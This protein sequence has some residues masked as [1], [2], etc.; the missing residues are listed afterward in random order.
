M[1]NSDTEDIRNQSPTGYVYDNESPDNSYQGF[2]KHKDHN[3]EAFMKSHKQEIAFSNRYLYYY[4]SLIRK[5]YG[6]VIRRGDDQP[7]ERYVGHLGEQPQR[8]ELPSE[9]HPKTLQAG[10]N[11][12]PVANEIILFR[13]R[14]RLLMGYCKEVH[15]RQVSEVDV[16]TE[17]ERHFR[18]HKTNLIYL[19]GI[20]VQSDA[21]ELYQYARTIR[22]LSQQIDLKL[23]WELALESDTALNFDEI[24]ELYWTDQQLDPTRW[25]A[26]YLYLNQ[27]CPY[28]TPTQDLYAPTS[29]EE[30]NQR[31]AI[32]NTRKQQADER[33]EFVN[34][35]RDEKDTDTA[36]LTK[37]QNI[38]LSHI[39]QYALWGQEASRSTEARNILSDL[40]PK[41]KNYK[42]LAFDCLVSKGIWQADEILDLHRAEIPTS[43]TKEVREESKTLFSD[44]DTKIRKHFQRGLFAIQSTDLPKLALSYRKPLFS[45]PE[46]SLHIP[47]LSAIISP[48][49]KCDHAAAERLQ[50]LT[51]PDQTL[52]LLPQ[53]LSFSTE[54]AIPTLNLTWQMDRK[55]RLKSFNITPSV[56][57][58]QTEL[59]PDEME[60]AQHNNAHIYHRAITFLTQLTNRLQERR[61]PR[62]PNIDLPDL[63]LIANGDQTTI[64]PIPNQLAHRVINELSILS[65]V[66]IGRWCQENDLPAIYEIRDKVEDIETIQ[67]IEHPVVRRHEIARNTPQ[68]KKSE[69][70]EFH[71]A[72]GVS[73]YCPIYDANN[74]YSHL[75]MQRQINH[76][77]QHNTP[78]YTDEHLHTLRFQIQDIHAI[79]KGIVFRRQRDLLLQHWDQ[80]IGQ[81][82]EA[83]VL[84]IK[85]H[86][87]LVELKTAPFKTIVYP[88]HTVQL[89][90]ELT[91]RL[92]G[93]NAPQAHFTV[94]PPLSVSQ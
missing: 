44:F 37:R 86:G 56:S 77:L 40:C 70:P 22:D 84:H 89:G 94:V 91:L 8:K 57:T 49:S 23:I 82:F 76:Y 68:T 14:K 43:F 62:D 3:A 93:I 30:M 61:T 25:L 27:N 81:E 46:F 12:L 10:R 78:Q 36:T 35:L 29:R 28:F 9:A 1:G 24:A 38:W 85:R 66:A 72:L 79:A 47:D 32:H 63:R 34:W 19:T 48:Q 17:D 92:T 4:A 16:Q 80:H 6:F 67:H 50:T 87:V 42:G 55:G 11:E 20:T 13:F 39:Q 88:N 15:A 26:L 73:T 33:E 52:P 51:L 64:D 71:H 7:D 54:H 90:D 21:Q 74:D 31:F 60:R 83:T 53:S 5:L 65:G 45:G 18:F 58:L 59:T 69:S 2:L 75:V 41:T